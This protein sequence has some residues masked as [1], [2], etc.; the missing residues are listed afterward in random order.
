MQV[1]RLI[2]ENGTTERKISVPIPADFCT[3]GQLV[4]IIGII[5]T[6]YEEPG[7]CLESSP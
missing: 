5:E 3:A 2:L 6:I 4:R 1:R 7:L